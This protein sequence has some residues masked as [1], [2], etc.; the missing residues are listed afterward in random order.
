MR[1][2]LLIR[3]QELCLVLMSLLIRSRCFMTLPPHPPSLNAVNRVLFGLLDAIPVVSALLVLEHDGHVAS[4]VQIASC[5][6]DDGASGYGTA[7]GLQRV[8]S[9]DLCRG[10]GKVMTLY[11]IQPT[12]GSVAFL[13]I[14]IS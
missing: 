13:K 2:S 12:I 5:D 6:V 14:S 9:G 11:I 7:A 3:A 8:Q 10:G 4:G 1:V